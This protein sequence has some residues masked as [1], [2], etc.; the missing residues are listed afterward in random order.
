[1]RTLRSRE[2]TSPQ[3]FATSTVKSPERWLER[4]ERDGHAIE[5]MIAIA[6]EERVQERI[7][8]GLRLREGLALTP[9]I[10][11][12]LDHDKLHLYEQKGLL[13]QSEGHLRAT[14]QG[15]L[16]LNRLLAEIVI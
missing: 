9:N 11:V 14:H 6:Q 15:W 2:S 16:V 7:L 1:M 8:T 5:Q 10:A 4:T 3:W 13:R 12:Q